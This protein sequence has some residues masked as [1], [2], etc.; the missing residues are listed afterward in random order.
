[1][2]DVPRWD[3]TALYASVEAQSLE[4][5][6]RQSEEAFAAL[7][8]ACAACESAQLPELLA[9]FDRAA[10]AFSQPQTYIILVAM[11]QPMTAALSL[12]W[13]WLISPVW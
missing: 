6:L 1:M 8:A 4:E 5:A 12:W 11:T 9:R 7:A 10:L 13:I 3:L 2:N